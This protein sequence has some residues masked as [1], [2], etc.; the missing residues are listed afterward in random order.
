MA[1]IME[2]DK[3]ASL[4]RGLSVIQSMIDISTDRL[5]GLRTQCNSSAELTQ[6]E[7]RTLETKL[8]KMFSELLMTKAKLPDHMPKVPTNAT[9]IKQW[10]RVVGECHGCCPFFVCR[11]QHFHVKN[12]TEQP[13]INLVVVLI[14][15]HPPP[16]PPSVPVA[17]VAAAAVRAAKLYNTP[18]PPVPYCADGGR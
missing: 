13:A 12:F 7:I 4:R 1:N 14:C 9:E 18:V 15:V 2:N 5:E 10:L 8:V 11:I 6:H 16:P 17:A 3:E